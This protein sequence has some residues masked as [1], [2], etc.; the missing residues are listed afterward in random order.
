MIPDDEIT[1]PCI[2]NG[3]RILSES[4]I[5]TSRR[6]SHRHVDERCC[7]AEPEKQ[8]CW[9]GALRGNH[10]RGRF[11]EPSSPS[12]GKAAHEIEILSGANYPVR[13]ELDRAHD[14]LVE[15]LRLLGHSGTTNQKNVRS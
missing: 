7:R 1:P 13:S 14:T 6:F 9:R 11:L 4:V 12:S 2:F 5:K 10:P 8:P 15:T 3:W